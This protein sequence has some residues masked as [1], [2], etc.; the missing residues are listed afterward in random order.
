[1]QD[2]FLKYRNGIIGI[3]THIPTP[4]GEN[5]PIVYADWTASGRCFSPIENR[6]QNEIMPLVANTHTETSA[7]GMAMT[8]AYH[9][10]RN[11]IKQ[12]V[13]ANSNDMIITSGSG[14]TGMVNKFQRILGLR[15]HGKL[16]LHPKEEE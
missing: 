3:D 6:I 13:H 5:L 1:M 12:H 15:V 10:A 8:Y 7:T 4:T 14:M 2:Y 16:A 11:S 9:Q